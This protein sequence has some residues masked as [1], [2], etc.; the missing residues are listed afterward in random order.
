MEMFYKIVIMV[1]TVLLILILA[2]MG[3]M[4]TDKSISGGNMVSFPPAKNSC[5]DNW[6]A[7]I[8]KRDNGE[9][10]VYCEIPH[11]T[12]K[13]VGVLMNQSNEQIDLTNSQATIGYNESI[14]S[15]RAVIDFNHNSWAAMGTT[16]DCAK[17]S[18]AKSNDIQWDGI[19]NYSK[20]E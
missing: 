14:F 19:T 9:E 15:K 20:C 12:M 8:K 5:P 2:Y 10:N 16:P 7:R 11:D 13:N 17:R 1:A 18:W 6:V 4:M 3:I